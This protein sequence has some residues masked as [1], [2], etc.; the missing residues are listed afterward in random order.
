MDVFEK[1]KDACVRVT[2]EKIKGTTVS[3]QYIVHGSPPM[4]T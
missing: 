4:L 2:F 3:M 1:H